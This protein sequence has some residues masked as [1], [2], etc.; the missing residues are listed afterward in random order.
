MVGRGRRSSGL[1]LLLKEANLSFQGF[2]APGV[3]ISSLILQLITLFLERLDLPLDKV[4]VLLRQ[5]ARLFAFPTA[6]RGIIGPSGGR[7]GYCQ[8]QGDRSRQPADESHRHLLEA[9]PWWGTLAISKRS[10]FRR[11]KCR[12]KFS[13]AFS[14]FWRQ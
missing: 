11:R 4:P 8:H 3:R 9:P 5:V 6:V 1:L 10:D 13:C 2:D 14:Y 7:V 12:T